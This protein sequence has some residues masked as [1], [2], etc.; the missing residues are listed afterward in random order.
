[1]RAPE[2]VMQNAA[3]SSSEVEIDNVH[4]IMAFGHD[5]AALQHHLKYDIR[6]GSF[7]IRPRRLSY[8]T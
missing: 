8:D 3:L 1:M 2:P 6:Q 5:S 7:G 4:R